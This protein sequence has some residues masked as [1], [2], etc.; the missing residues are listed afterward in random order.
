M[1]GSIQ[2]RGDRTYRISVE[3]DRDPETGRRRRIW[4]TISGTKRDAEARLAELIRE[5]ETGIAA[6]PS[7]LT[8]A[9]WLRQWLEMRRPHLRETT[10]ERYRTAARV[11]LIPALGRHR[12]Q[13]LRPL[14]VQAAYAGWLGDGLSPTTV[15]SL[16]RVLHRAL[17][18]AV[19]LQLVVRN[20][21]DAV[22]APAPGRRLPDLQAVRPSA[23]LASLADV[24]HPWR[25]LVV[26]AL[27]TGMR[28]GELA[29]LQWGDVDLD[30]ATVAIRRSRTITH[31]GTIV[32]GPTK[33]LAGERVVPL[34]ADAVRELRAWR[35]EQLALRMAAGAG[36]AGDEW[37]F[38]AGTEPL[39]PDAI[40]AWW[41][42]HAQRHGLRLRL[43]D[44]RHAAAT[45]M[46]ERGVPP[47][48]I[49]EVLGHSRASFTL[50]VYA[51]AP[52]M[53]S[54][55]AA[56]ETLARALREG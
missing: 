24:G 14:H 32:E 30:A 26:L 17:E 23:V 48:V 52:D 19:R 51:G 41:G 21:T 8:V 11:H 25:A 46:A 2:R 3:L 37:V 40:T 13:E 54:R 42:R 36:W 29:G 12:L 18:D 10:L 7:R 34:A 15:A 49:A 16:H 6:E 28:R 55:R 31:R 33:S 20:V 50:D 44:L 1:R 4:E 47:R 39:R 27:H 38:T 56:V 45:L 22:E 43:H 53:A 5:V 9:D 35:R